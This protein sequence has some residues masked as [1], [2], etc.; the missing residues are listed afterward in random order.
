MRIRRRVDADIAACVELLLRVHRS[1][2]YPL[3]LPT[4]DVEGFFASDSEAA[5]WVA[6]REG[7]LVGHVALRSTPGDPTLVAA[8]RAT[9]LRPHRL[10]MVS[11]LFVAPDLRRAGLGRTLLRQATGHARSLGQRAV[12]DVGQ[13][14]RAPVALYESEGWSRVDAL[15][16]TLDQDTVLDLWV[17][18]SPEMPDAS[19]GHPILASPS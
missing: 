12:L 2:G 5:A 10:V 11:R 18:V 7:H 15:H 1:D 14:L 4:E 19:A 8:A 6:E 16:L 3:H 13:T 9:G 17:Y